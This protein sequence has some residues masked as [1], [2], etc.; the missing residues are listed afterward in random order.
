MISNLQNDF[1]KHFCSTGTFACW[2]KS[3]LRTLYSGISF[4]MWSNGRQRPTPS[5]VCCLGLRG[6][7]ST[8]A[9]SVKNS[10]R[11]KCV[12]N[13]D[14]VFDCAYKDWLQVEL[15]NAVKNASS[16]FCHEQSR[17]QEEKKNKEKYEANGV[18]TADI[19]SLKVK[20]KCLFEHCSVQDRIV[21]KN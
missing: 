9:F 15:R 8:Y 2:V 3:D 10:R 21:L 7:V 12:F 11:G 1:S 14:W 5:S 18:V 17:Q 13:C 4:S 16:E 19:S 20:Q 6:F